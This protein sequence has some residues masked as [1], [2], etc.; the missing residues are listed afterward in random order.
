MILNTVQIVNKLKGSPKID[1]YKSH[2][3]GHRL[4]LPRILQLFKVEI[5]QWHTV[6]NVILSTVQAVNESNP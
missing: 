5:V 4:N 2:Q 1:D 6:L 3:A